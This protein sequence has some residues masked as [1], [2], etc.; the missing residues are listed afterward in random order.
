MCMN[1]LPCNY[2]P[3]WVFQQ[4]GDISH[5]LTLTD[6]LWADCLYLLQSYNNSY[7]TATQLYIIIGISTGDSGVGE[8]KRLKLKKINDLVMWKMSI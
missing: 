5:T 8:Q 4:G 3:F 7:H 1:V 2:K 6:K